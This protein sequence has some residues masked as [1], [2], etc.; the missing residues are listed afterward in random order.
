MISQNRSQA[1]FVKKVSLALK[2]FSFTEKTVFSLFFITLI[3]SGLL[4]VWGINKHFL[5]DVPNK[6]GSLVE[7][8]V[9]SPR[10]VNPLLAVYDADKDLT[11]L[12][13]S[14]LLKATPD[15]SLINDLSQDFSIS[16]D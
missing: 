5:T 1:P 12:I 11:S 13:Y 2:T 7:G 8:V 15:G 10:F 3:I 4:L 14:G 6:G 9:G 16:E